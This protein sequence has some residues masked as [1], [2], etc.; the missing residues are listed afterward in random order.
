MKIK[1]LKEYLDACSDDLE[2]KIIR[3]GDIPDTEA[4]TVEGA[5]S[6]LTTERESVK[7]RI[8]MKLSRTSASSVKCDGS[9]RWRR[10]GNA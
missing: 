8:L 3:D 1:E 10:V 2:I 7:R 9:V 6:A 5:Y 4:H